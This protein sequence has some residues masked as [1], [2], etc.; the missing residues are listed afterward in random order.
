MPLMAYAANIQRV[1][2]DTAVRLTPRHLWTFG[3]E[4]LDFARP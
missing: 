1:M 2:T 4:A 3:R